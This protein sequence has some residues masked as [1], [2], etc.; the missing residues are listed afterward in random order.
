M[1][2]PE[3]VGFA[4]DFVFS[5]NDAEHYQHLGGL[6][7]RTNERGLVF[8]SDKCEIRCNKITFFGNVY[9]VEGVPPDPSKL[10]DIRAMPVPAGKDELKLSWDC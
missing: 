7:Q 10:D 9:S 8:N 6:M 5:E 2:L 1:G 3:I 4:D